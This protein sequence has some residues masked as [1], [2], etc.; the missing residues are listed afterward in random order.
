MHQ[1]SANAMLKVLCPA[2]YYAQIIKTSYVAQNTYREIGTYLHMHLNRLG[3][4][5][6]Y[7]WLKSARICK[8]L[9]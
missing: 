1:F 7:S 9:P 5:M 2:P 8:N 3:S 6:S 4:H